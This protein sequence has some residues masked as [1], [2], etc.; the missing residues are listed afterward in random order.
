MRIT[1]LF[2][3]IILIISL[4]ICSFLILFK[5]VNIKKSILNFFTG[6][7]E[8]VDEKAIYQ[9]GKIVGKVGGDIKEL[10][11]K[12]VFQ[13]L[14]DTVYLKR[15]LPFK[16]KRVQFIIKKYGTTALMGFVPGEGMKEAVIDNVICEKVR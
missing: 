2:K 4:A 5:P 8:V 3:I 10:N 12:I 9:D 7:V 6:W 16:Y 14:Y 15:N 11:G 13:K 1:R